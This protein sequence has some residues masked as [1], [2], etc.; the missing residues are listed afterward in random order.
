MK[1]IKKINLDR[2]KV[3]RVERKYLIKN[4]ATGKYVGGITYDHVLEYVPGKKKKQRVSKLILW[5]HNGNYYNDIEE[6]NN[7]IDNIVCH[8]LG[9]SLETCEIISFDQITLTETV[10]KLNLKTRKE[11]FEQEHLIRKLKG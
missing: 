5:E 2:S 10:G 1:N 11:K 9:A 7:I 6:V 8:G 3:E 4:N